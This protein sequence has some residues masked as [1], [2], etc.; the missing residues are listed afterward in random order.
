MKRTLLFLAAL[1]VMASANAYDLY[2]V[3]DFNNWVASED[4]KMTEVSN[5]HELEYR[6]STPITEFRITDGDPDFNGSYNYGA[7]PAE[8]QE[9]GTT[10]FVINGFPNNVKLAEPVTNVKIWINGPD[11]ECMVTALPDEP[12]NEYRDLYLVGEDYG[13]WGLDES[14]KFDTT[15][16]VTYTLELEDGLTKEWKIFDG[17]WDYSFGKGSEDVENHVETPAYFKSNSNFTG[18]FTGKTTITFVIVEGSE[19]EYSPIASTV[20]VDAEG[21]LTP[22]LYAVGNFNGWNVADENAILKETDTEGVYELTLDDSLFE[23]SLKEFKITNGSWTG[24]YNI[25]VQTAGTQTLGEPISVVNSGDPKNIAFDDFVRNAKI[26]FDSNNM[27]V[28]VTGEVITDVTYAY[29]LSGHWDISVDAWSDVEMSEENGVWTKAEFKVEDPCEFGIKKVVAETGSQVEW[30]SAANDVN[31]VLDT[32]LACQLNGSNFSIKAGE[33]T[34]AFDPENLTLTVTGTEAGDEPV[35]HELYIV[36][37]CTNNALNEAYKMTRN[38]NV[39]TI[40]LEEGLT[41]EWRIYDGTWSYSFG[42]GANNMISAGVNYEAWFNSI[43]NFY[44]DFAGKTTVTLTVEDG[45]DEQDSEIPATLYVQTV[46]T[47]VEGVEAES[48][49]AI[50]FNLQGVRVAEPANGLYIKVQGNKAEKVTF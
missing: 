50:Y 21:V 43:T 17:T 34:F 23:A 26:V 40:E 11:M 49:E 38:E 19:E 16:G 24:T 1:G 36:G 14:Y 35:V 48:A 9:L 2:V 7:V 13:N 44:S 30:Y 4:C 25:G 18:N 6:G 32:P 3:G 12:V 10:I 27:N 45:S 15:D 29:V 28:T 20:T 39:Y 8:P 5:G 22:T 31:V 47:G 41:G 33:Y 37:D 46:S 42:A